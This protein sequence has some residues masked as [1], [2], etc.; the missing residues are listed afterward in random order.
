MRVLLDECVPIP[1]K[2][3]FTEFDA[4][5]VRHM[6]W[7]TIKNGALFL[8]AAEEFDAVLTVDAPRLHGR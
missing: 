8:K 4:R 1:L 5:T 3:E 7:L 2:R 6:R